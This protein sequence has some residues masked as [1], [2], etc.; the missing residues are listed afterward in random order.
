MRRKALSL[1]QRITGKLS[2][3]RFSLLQW[4]QMNPLRLHVKTTLLV[5]AI[6]LA[7]FLA[8]LLLVSVRMVN[9]VR[10]D[11]KALARLQA[12]SV[13]RQITLMSMPRD[14]D[15]LNRA[16]SQAQAA[17]PNVIA[18]RL[19]ILT[20]N[21]LI[22]AS[23]DSEDSEITAQDGLPKE[24]YDYAIAIIRHQ[25][26]FTGIS[27]LRD[28]MIE[29]EYEINYRVFAPVTDH[30]RF[31]GFVE[32]TERLDNI[33]SIVKRFAQTAALL[34]L[35]AILLTT[36]AVYALFRYLV[37]RPMNELDEAMGRVKGGAFDLQARVSTQDEFG[38]L[39][40]GFNRMLERIRELTREREAQ[41]ETLRQRVREATAESQAAAERYRLIFDSNPLPMWVYDSTTLRFLTV[42]EAAV[43][44]Y[45]WTREA[46]LQMTIEDLY[47]P[48]DRPKLLADAARPTEEH[49][50]LEAAQHLRKDGSLIDVEVSLH[51]LMF[52]GRQARLV[53]ASDVTDK[54]RIEASVLRSQR[55]E[56]LG[57]LASGIAHDLNNIL[58]PLSIS[59]FLLRPKISDAG[60]YETLDTMEEVIERGSQLIKRVLSFAR[61]TEGERI[62]V[63]PER[64]LGEV[65]SIVKET[66]PKSIHIQ[67]SAT[68]KTGT[69]LGDPTQLHQVLMNLCV[70]ARDAMPQGGNLELEAKTIEIDEHEAQ[71]LPDAK[72]GR[73]VMISVKDTG[74]GIAPQVMDKIF[75]PFFTTKEQGKGTGL[76]MST[77]LGIVQSLGGFINVYSEPGE[78]TLFQIYLPAQDAGV[79]AEIPEEVVELPLGKG[80][81]ILLVD[82]EEPIRRVTRGMLEA[83]NYRVLTA[84]DGGKACAL[85]REKPDEIKLVLTDMMMP[86][87]DGA[88]TIRE[89]RRLN[90][91]LPVIASSGL[92][93]AGREEQARRLGAQ[94]FL[95]KPYTAVRLLRAL[96]ELLHDGQSNSGDEEK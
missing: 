45:G 86:V 53:I 88:S 3:S 60:G 51:D 35:A 9:L 76:G 1:V 80:E 6:T 14:Q 71:L 87:M 64:V 85:Y 30:G 79:E 38:R 4:A 83:S 65:V 23:A 21:E 93:E 22:V 41:Q 61:G 46:F 63:N 56:S 49:A 19:W 47:R 58:S 96:D 43:Q 32:V 92:A 28:F 78:G 40:M 50:Q 12:L 37:Y 74:T 72:P 31:Y 66:F 84:S 55:L 81:L 26:G 15:D 5:S 27:P 89:L 7:M 69:V 73:Y 34:A 29:K 10:E 18:V 95:S 17:R 62:P 77:S 48:Q 54:K 59:T 90:P 44:N 75:D 94:K 24:I 91:H 39:A 2:E 70:N 33:P 16:I 57:T 42:N 36:L 20:S 8:L 25:E 82:D 68:G 67:F 52:E 13:A 11:E